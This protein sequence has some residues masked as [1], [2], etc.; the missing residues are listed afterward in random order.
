ME[1]CRAVNHRNIRCLVDSYHLW[2]ED[3]PLANVAAGADLLVHVHAADKE[4]RAPPG[5]SG[6]SD[7]QPLFTLLKKIRYAGGVSVESMP[8]PDMP[9][10]A[11]SI[12]GYLKE[13]WEK[14]G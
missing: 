10:T 7:Y 11:G 6:K 3:E 13:Q 4:G 8:W 5:R 12:L 2:L 9:S 1:V 14:A